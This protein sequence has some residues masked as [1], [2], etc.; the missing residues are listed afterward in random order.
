MKTGPL[1]V[2]LP[3][4]ETSFKVVVYMSELGKLQALES[5]LNP[6][7]LFSILG[8]M[9]LVQSIYAVV[10]KLFEPTVK[11]EGRLPSQ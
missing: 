1:I 11:G 4:F 10:S 5:I 8:P 3:C 7:A 6:K 2:C 9:S